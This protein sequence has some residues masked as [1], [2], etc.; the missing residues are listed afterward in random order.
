M[1]VPSEYN[2]I[3]GLLGLGEYIY[4]EILSEIRLISNAIQFLG[5][6]KKTLQ[7]KNHARFYKIMETLSISKD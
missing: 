4:L 7:L 1:T 3:G 2:V 5:V 6:C